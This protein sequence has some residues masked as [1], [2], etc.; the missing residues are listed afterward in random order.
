[1]NTAETNAIEPA[2]FQATTADSVQIDASALGLFTRMAIASTAVTEHE[3][4]AHLVLP[5]GYRHIDLSAAVEKAAAVPARKHGVVQL[6]DLESFLTYAEQ[7]G[8]ADRTYIYADVES[9]TLTAVFND[10]RPHLS[11]DLPGWRDHRAVYK[12]ELSREFENWMKNDRNSFE[13]E[14]FATFIEDNIADVIEPAGDVLLKVALTLQAK[15]DVNFS[16]ARRLDN[17]QVQFTYE[18]N[19]TA[20]AGGGAIEIPREFTLGMRLFKGGEGYRVKARLKYRIASGKLRFWYELERPHVAI[21][22]AFKTYV[23]QAGDSEFTLLVGK[24]G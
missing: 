19:T 20:S 6:G 7:Q 4:T 18:E 10:H 2:T 15:T 12:A 9:R 14:A 22:D 1:M 3:G 17:G 23:D 5:E 16:S 13:Q 21:E 24:A 8:Q 11:G